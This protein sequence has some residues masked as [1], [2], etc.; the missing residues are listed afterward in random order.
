MVHVVIDRYFSLFLK[1]LKIFFEDFL[2]Q[3]LSLIVPLNL[4]LD[5]K[6]LSGLF[7]LQG[8]GSGKMLVFLSSRDSVEFHY[9]LIRHC[10]SASSYDDRLHIYRLHGSMPQEVGD[11]RMSS[12]KFKW[13]I[14]HGGHLA[15]MYGGELLYFR[16]FL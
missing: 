10:L 15:V 2:N 6:F 7:P 9:A 11:I 1:G 3:R 12:R 5:I 14:C 13:G 8:S 4:F 16:I